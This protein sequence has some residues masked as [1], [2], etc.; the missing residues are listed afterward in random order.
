MTKTKNIP[1]IQKILERVADGTT[2]AKD[3]EEFSQ[4]LDAL[5]DQIAALEIKT[6]KIEHVY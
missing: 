2:T 4:I 5:D 1:R 3:A 6:R